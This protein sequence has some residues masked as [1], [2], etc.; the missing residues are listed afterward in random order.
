MMSSLNHTTA[1]LLLKLGY[2]HYL[3]SSYSDSLALETNSTTTN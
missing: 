1:Q 3:L 2:N